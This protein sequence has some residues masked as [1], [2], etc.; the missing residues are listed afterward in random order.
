MTINEQ[1]VASLE[2]D[3]T[4]RLMART[5]RE[6][7]FATCHHPNRFVSLANL[8]YE[9]TGTVHQPI[10]PKQ[11]GQQV[12]RASR[13]FEMIVRNGPTACEGATFYNAVPPPEMC[14]PLTVTKESGPVTIWAVYQICQ[15]IET[16]EPKMEGNAIVY[17]FD[18]WTKIAP[19]L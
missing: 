11:A 4:F 1:Q 13:L 8:P 19:K 15:N 17:V 18:R 6:I 16:H 14:L 12:F 10:Q 7:V 2:L 3:K 9:V 5:P